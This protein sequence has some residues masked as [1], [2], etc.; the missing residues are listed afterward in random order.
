MEAMTD[1]GATATPRAAWN[2]PVAE[3]PARDPRSSGKICVRVV[4]ASRFVEAGTPKRTNALR[5]MGFTAPDSEIRRESRR[6]ATN[7][8]ADSPRTSAANAA[9]ADRHTAHAMPTNVNLTTGWSRFRTNAGLRMD[10]N[11]MVP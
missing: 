9:S 5:S 6:V 10:L 8:R 4:S 1:P 11:A 7:R 3:V 2:T